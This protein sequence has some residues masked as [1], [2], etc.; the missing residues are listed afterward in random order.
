MER[1]AES[2]LFARCVEVSRWYEDDFSDSMHE[3]YGKAVSRGESPVE[4]RNHLLEEYPMIKPDRLT[5]MME[6]TYS[7]NKY[8]DI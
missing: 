6:G 2:E 4:V 3:K 7:C 1:I 8:E 5:E